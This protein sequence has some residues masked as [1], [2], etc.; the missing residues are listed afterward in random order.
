LEAIGISTTKP[1]LGLVDLQE[2]GVG[3]VPKTPLAVTLNFLSRLFN[4]SAISGIVIRTGNLAEDGQANAAEL[5]EKLHERGVPVVLKCQ[6]DDSLLKDVDLRILV[7]VII[8]SACIL[9]NGERRDYFRSQLLRDTMVRCAEERI[10]RPEF[11][12]GFHDVWET[13]PRAA[14]VR[15]AS[16]IAQHFGAVLEFEPSRLSG[17]VQ[18]NTAKL[19]VSMSGFEY[20]RR[21]ETCEVSLNGQRE[22]ICCH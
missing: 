21:S 11:F 22:L 7:G 19:P 20:L 18:M 6:H 10:E 14:V 12:V 1:I 8:E 2:L 3:R 17:P 5:L 4:E 15:R 13:R 16:K 9:P